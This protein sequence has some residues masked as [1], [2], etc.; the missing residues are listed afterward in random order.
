[1]LMTRLSLHSSA[2]ICKTRI[3]S[4]H[5]GHKASH[6]NPCSFI[7][8][9][10]ATEQRSAEDWRDSPATAAPIQ[11][12]VFRLRQPTHHTP[13]SFG[14]SLASEYALLTVKQQGKGRGTAGGWAS[15]P[16][17]PFATMIDI[18]CRG[19]LPSPAE[20]THPCRLEEY[21]TRSMRSA[22]GDDS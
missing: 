16:R 9:G 21:E 4:H 13:T 17:L 22:G 15:N 19:V 3:R 10:S 1:M 12:G 20:P 8:I 6:S 7:V 18:S 11:A 5:V 14:G 2:A